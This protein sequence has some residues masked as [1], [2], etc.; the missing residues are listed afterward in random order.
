[1]EKEEIKNLFQK[2][3]TTIKM[4]RVNLF[5]KRLYMTDSPFK[6][7]SGL[8]GALD[9]VKFKGNQEVK[10]VGKWRDMMI[11][12]LGGVQAQQSYLQS[13]A[14]FGTLLHE[15]I[16]RAWINRKLDWK[17]EQEYAEKYFHESA[18]ENKIEPNIMVIRQQVFEYCKAA[19]ALL[20]FLH[21]QVEE[22]YAVEG[23]AKSEH[24][25]I[26]TPIDLFCLLK[27]G[28]TVTLNI[29]T[30]SQFSDGHREQCA[31]ERMMWNVTYPNNQAMATGLIRPK[32]WSLKKGV[33]TYELEIIDHDT[34][35]KLLDSAIARLMIAKTDENST[36]LNYPR[37]NRF[38]NGVTRMGEAVRIEVQTLEAMF[39]EKQ[40]KEA[41]LF[42]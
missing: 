32:D 29:K 10:R 39:A 22:L 38:F 7:Y 18:I 26:A 3:M 6:L 13:M 11:E 16:V 17:E 25:E 40:E 33:P 34:E 15:C 21:E 4:F 5:Q 35:K 28:R 30:S 19:A 23:M 14:D 37:E 12:N 36:Y 41:T 20:T 31:M 1:M 8:T 42:N 9:V 2:G 27:D 24:L